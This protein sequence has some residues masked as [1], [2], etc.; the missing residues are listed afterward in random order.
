MSQRRD[1]SKDLE[2][3]HC[4]TCGATASVTSVTGLSSC[5]RHHRSPANQAR[6]DPLDGRMLTDEY[7]VV[8]HWMWIWKVGDRYACQVCGERTTRFLYRN[9]ET[10]GRFCAAHAPDR[11]YVDGSACVD[12]GA[13]SRWWDV[14]GRSRCEDHHIPTPVCV[15][16]RVDL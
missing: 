12:C 13:A 2:P 9:A 11:P 10:I 16:Q 14:D 1:T 5:T 4:V 7:L 8:P 15:P 6:F 3:R